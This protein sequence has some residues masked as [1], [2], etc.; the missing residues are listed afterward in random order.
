MN[1][2]AHIFLSEYHIEFQIGNYLADPLKGK[3]WE[4]ASKELKHGM[5]VHTVIDSFTDKHPLFKQSKQ[6]LGNKGLLKAIVID[7]TYDY[8]LTKNWNHFSNITIDTFLNQFYKNAYLTLPKLP[9][10]A[11]TPLKRMI[12]FDLLNKYQNL[13]DLYHAFLRVDKRL[14]IRLK[15][16]DQVVSYYEMVCKEIELIEKDFM[17]FFPELCQEV[18]QHVKE[19][20]IKHWKIS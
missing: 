15:Q 2:L 5:K 13:E 3:S 12:D 8:L 6:R 16:R 11:S 19:D 10:H 9:I 14:S 18:R 20:K 7:L 1:W 17:L 4:S